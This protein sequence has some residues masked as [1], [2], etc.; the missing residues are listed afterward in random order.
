VGGLNVEG[1]PQHTDAFDQFIDDGEYLSAQLVAAVHED[2]MSTK[3]DRKDVKRWIKFGRESRE[4]LTERL[5]TSR[6][7][8]AF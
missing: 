8:A 4:K 7:F 3:L 5:T 2:P 6:R 1:W